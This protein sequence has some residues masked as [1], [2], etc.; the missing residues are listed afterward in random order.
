MNLCLF[1]S[2]LNIPAYRLTLT[3][4]NSFYIATSC[5]VLRDVGVG[6]VSSTQY[7][8]ERFPEKSFLSS[9]VTCCLFIRMHRSYS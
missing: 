9:Q 4:A 6:G 3:V 1:L 7:R 8:K 2:L 5:N